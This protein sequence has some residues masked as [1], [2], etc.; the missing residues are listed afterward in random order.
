M[1]TCLSCGKEFIKKTEFDSDVCPTCLGIENNYLYNAKR[2]LVDLIYSQARV[3]NLVVTFASTEDI[4]N[5]IPVNATP[6]T[7]NKVCCLRD[8][9]KYIF[10]NIY[11]KC[12]LVFLEELHEIIARFDVDYRYLGKVRQDPVFISGTNWMPSVPNVDLI[13]NSLKHVE[14]VE[15]AYLAGFTVMRE[16]L[17]KDCNKRVGSFIINKLLI[18]KELGVFIV[19]DSLDGVYKRK[20]VEFYESNNASSLIKWCLEN[21]HRKL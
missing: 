11:K 8:G 18:E 17:F 15:G 2:I 20:L 13:E 4:L 5:N 6:L 3:E 16:Q 19:P 7:I 9:W 12:D 10:E 14:T 1:S 21:C